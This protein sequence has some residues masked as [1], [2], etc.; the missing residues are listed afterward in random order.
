MKRMHV[1]VSLLVVA[2]LGCALAQGAEGATRQG[3]ARAA[4][5]SEAR[6]LPEAKPL[7][8][9]FPK[10]DPAPESVVKLVPAV[11][12][13]HP[14][15]LFTA[16]DVPAMR[17]FAQNEGAAFF[18]QLKSYVG[19][20]DIPGDLSFLTNATNAQR[21]GLWRLPTV[22]LHYVLTG[23]RRSFG[24]C[25]AAMKALME[26]DHWEMGGEQDS[27]MG[28]ANVMIGAALA[29]DWLYNDLDPAFREAYRQK[30]LL[31]ARRMYYLGHLGKGGSLGYWRSDPQNNHRWHR[32]AGL[33]LCILAVA[34][35]GPGY[36]WLL[37][38][39]KEELEFITKWL[40][41]DGTSHESPS[42]MIFGGAHL[43][44]ALDAADRCLGTSFCDIP[45]VRENVSF[46]MQTLT[47]GLED[48][49]CFGDSGG[50]G[51]YSNYLYL[52]AA[53]HGMK[54]HMDGLRKH[55]A[56]N[57]GAYWLGW[58]SLVWFDPTLTGGSVDNLPKA[59]L[60]DDLG[61]AF[62]REGWAKDDVAVMLKAAPYGGFKLNQYRNEND[63][64]YIN[65]AHDDP[66]ANMFQLYADGE[67]LAC[68]DGYASN[69]VTSSHNTILVNGK[70]QE[71]E[72]QHWTQPLNGRDMKGMA[73]ATTW[74]DAGDVV[75]A[76]G[77]AGGA[78]A[79][80][81]RF[82]RTVIWVNGQ[83]VLVLD[84]VRAPKPAEITWLMQGAELEPVDASQGA[85][86]LKKGAAQCEFQVV[87]DK[88]LT[89]TIGEST[90]DARGRSM[91]LKQ[92][93]AKA[94]GG[95]VR[96]AAVFDPWKRGK[97]RLK[98]AAQGD[99]ATLAVSGPGVDDRWVWQ[100]SPDAATPSTLWG[101]GGSVVLGMPDKVERPL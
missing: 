85:Y 34:G 73:W 30:L 47:P 68:D 46:R 26:L 22:G 32:N 87:A 78:Y 77:E 50:M 37:G 23:D 19:S 59:K 79:D 20:G 76:E 35:D 13:R 5:A 21:E 88:P 33:T 71:G 96:I 29:Y 8:N 92:L 75:V 67:V 41:D 18:E 101:R 64:H 97:L 81:D 100:L 11:R 10:V 58:F 16:E 63:L 93:Q 52:C 42:Y 61:L 69:K 80:L 84:D 66:D 55:A 51:S 56:L 94:S 25:V 65:V 48:V 28:A 1:I 74:K 17:E 2:I 82:R 54:D 38:K 4:G 49:F 86:R 27:G 91:G 72:G 90:A 89:A 95:A 62:V 53:R 43:M 7:D 99:A 6:P 24:R 44:L 45:F 14:R 15:L 60:F 57:S 3:R 36:E 9:E 31:Q 12:G 83:Y 40:P 39:T 98:M 70:G